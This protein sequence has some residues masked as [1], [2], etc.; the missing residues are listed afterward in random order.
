MITDYINKYPNLEEL[1]KELYKNNILTKDYIEEGMMLIYHKY[2]QKAVSDLERECRS[3]VIDRNT[4]EIISYSCSDPVINNDAL[5]YL[6][7]NSNKEKI[8]TKCY[9][10]TLL[11]LFFKDK[12]FLSTRR[13]LNSNDSVWGS[14]EKSHYSMF[15]DVLNSSG[16]ESF[17]SFTSVLNKENCYYFVLI[18]YQNKNIVDYVSEFGSEYKKLV[19]PFIRDMKTQKELDIY[20]PELIPDFNKILSNNIFVSEKLDNLETFDQSNQQNQFQLPPVTEGIIIRFTDTN[21]I[22]KLQSKAYQFAKS[23]GSDKNIFMGLIHL[24]QKDKLK[25][26][27]ENKTNYHLKKILNPMKTD[28]SYDTIGTIDALFKVCTS[29]LFELFKKLW[30]IK[31]GKHLNNELYNLIPK[32]YKDILFGVRGIYYKKKNNLQIT[33][34]YNFLKSV[35]VENFCALNKMRRLMF[36]WCKINDKLSDFNTVS[37]KCDKIHLKLAAIYSNKLFPNIL[38]EDLPPVKIEKTQ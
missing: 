11:S 29:E 30:D 15:M 25:E 24:Y 10:G 31:T 14:D 13:C 33:D 4:K 27:L 9:E 21:R 35:P 12:W 3:I 26:F 16:F 5:D 17:E 1:R 32:E 20:N 8:I 19:I 6:L 37:S 36:N 34:I 22:F 28:E 18:H 38:N 7:V 2:E 23:I